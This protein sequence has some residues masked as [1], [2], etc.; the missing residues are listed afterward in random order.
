MMIEPGLTPPPGVTPNFDNPPRGV[1]DWTLA[2]NVL[3]LSFVTTLVVLRLWARYR[4]TAKIGIDDISCI[5]AYIGFVGYSSIDLL[6]LR[7]GGGINQWN[8]PKHKVTPYSQAVY[9]TMVVYGPTVF[10]TKC[11][12]LLFLT[13]VFAPFDRYCRFIFAFLGV[14]GIYY[15]LMLFLKIF[16]CRPIPKF[17]NMALEGQ[18]F[19][20]RALIMTD[21]VISLISDIAVLLIPCPLANFLKVSTKAKLKIGAVF[22]AGGIAC[23][24]SLVRLV[25]IINDSASLDQTWAFTMI[26]LWG[27]AEVAIGLIAS[28]FPMIPMLWKH[29]HRERTRTISNSYSN[30]YSNAR[31]SGFE[32]MGS[33]SNRTARSKLHASISANRDTLVENGSDEN[34]LIAGHPNHMLT[35]KCHAGDEFDKAECG[36]SDASQKRRS[37]DDTRIM[38]TVEVEVH[39]TLGKN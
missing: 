36:D 38:R 5:L 1:A 17:W 12:I 24:C 22:G 32:M 35:T 3:G 29:I 37:F 10:A 23:V 30:G 21:N 19:N 20:Q 14:M 16:I 4:V 9:S 11:S 31:H 8:V 28:C 34:I 15:T 2:V 26:N 7:F 39:E 6:M 25:E 18:C 33:H 27:I 13:R